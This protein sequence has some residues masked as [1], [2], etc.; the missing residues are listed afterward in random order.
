[1][2][3]L[4]DTAML[5]FQNNCNVPEARVVRACWHELKPHVCRQLNNPNDTKKPDGP[6]S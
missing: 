6:P 5:V 1:M 3:D 4:L 2:S